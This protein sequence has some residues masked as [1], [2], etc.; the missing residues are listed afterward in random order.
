VRDLKTFS[1]VDGDHRARIDLRAVIESSINLA[2]NEIRYRARLVED[3]GAPPPVLA[4]EARLGQVFLNLLVNAAQAIPEGHVDENE[5][6]VTTRTDERGRAV[7]EIRDSGAGIPRESL[8]HIFEPFFTTKPRGEGTGLGLSICRNIVAALQGEILIEGAAG[9]GTV[10]RVVLPAA[11]QKIETAPAASPGPAPVAQA[12]R[13]RVLVVDDEPSICK[14]LRRALREHDVVT[15][16]SARE[17]LE[18]IRLGE[19]FDVVLTDLVMPEMTGMELHANLLALAPDQAER[20]VLVTG[21]AFTQAAREFLTIVPNARI[22][23][24]FDPA[25][26]RALVRGF[27]S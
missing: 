16:T 3:Y 27:V 9:G 4:N 24:P 1:R 26:V 21:G 7:V 25:A 2:F 23:K 10:V 12:R 15:C 17:A 20:I 22:E 18:R 5:I 6:R 14:A 19:R 8:G 13:G 11:P